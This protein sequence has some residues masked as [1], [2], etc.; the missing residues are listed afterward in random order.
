MTVVQ[1]KALFF[2]TDL[3][4]DFNV[5]SSEINIITSVGNSVQ[6]IAFPAGWLFDRYGPRPMI[7]LGVFL[8]VPGWML[9]GMRPC[10]L[11]SLVSLVSDSWNCGW[12]YHAAFSDVHS[13]LFAAG[14]RQHLCVYECFAHG[15]AKLLALTSWQG[16]AI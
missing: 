10:L 13:V 6:L 15:C 1:S 3:E 11:R 4:D 2:Q 8:L 14:S 12:P 7:V 9:L 5:T 16:D